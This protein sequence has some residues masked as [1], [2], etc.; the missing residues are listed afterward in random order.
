MELDMCYL[1]DSRTVMRGL[2]AAGVRVQCIVTS[3]PYWGLRDYGVGGQLGLEPTMNEFLANMVDV[4]ELCRQLMVD[5]GTLWLNMGDAYANDG[6]WG[7]STGGKHV[8]ALHGDTS[9]GRAKTSTGLRP[10]NLMGQPWRLAFALQDAG[11]NL[12]QDIIWHKPNPMPESV[13]DR[14]TKSHEYLFLMTKGERYYFDSDAMREPA[15]YGPTPTGVGFGHGFEEQPKARVRTPAGWDTGDG[16]HRELTGRY[17]KRNS[18]ARETKY[19]AG[20]HGKTAQHRSDR[21][22]V[23]YS[24]TRNKRSVWTIPTQ[25]YEGAHFATF[26]EAL[27][28]PCILAGSRPGDIVFDPF[29]GSGT[30]ASVAQRLGRRWLGAELNPDYLAL[31]AERTRQGG[32]CLETV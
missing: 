11:W 28:E 19:S 15:V 1:G 20:T 3:P 10:K 16:A 31:Q 14:C 13:R 5:D 25:A 4:F 2:I 21:K 24:Q 30:V 12:R 29:M 22:D 18:F 26:P 32:L 7:G 23:D 17:S 9:V 27:V 6:K 8:K